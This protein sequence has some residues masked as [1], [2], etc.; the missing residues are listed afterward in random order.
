M[1]DYVTD[2]LEFLNRQPPDT[3]IEMGRVLISGGIATIA[4]E[5]SDMDATVAAD[6]NR[7]WAAGLALEYGASPTD[8]GYGLT[9]RQDD[10]LRFIH[11]YMAEHSKAPSYSEIGDG[12][13]LTSKGS[14]A[15][16]LRGLEE[17]GLI[18][19]LP[20]RN[21]SLKLVEPSPK[22]QSREVA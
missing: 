21:R 9:G 12:I 15:R 5:M 8:A 7:H 4:N 10:A 13:G 17:R 22:H 2:A 14:V 16:L 19:R 18:K 11:G 1:T 6:E 20:R 3:R